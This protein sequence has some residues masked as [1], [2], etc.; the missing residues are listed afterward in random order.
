MDL[1]DGE[2]AGRSCG[3]NG[4]MVEDLWAEVRRV[5]EAASRSGALL[6]IQTSFRTLEDGG[7][8]FIVRV[9]ENLARKDAE[10]RAVLEGKARKK[11]E[12][13][14]LPYDEELFVADVSDSHVCLLN[15]YNVLEHHLLIVTRHFEH[16]DQLL[17]VEDFAALQAC[18]DRVEG[19]GFYN[20]GVIAGASQPHKHL[21]L[22]PLPLAA[23][24]DEIPIAGALSEASFEDGIGVV[25]TL[26][27]D[28]SLSCLSGDEKGR[29]LHDKYLELMD[30]VELSPTGAEPIPRA[31]YNLLVTS[32]WMLVVPRAEEHGAPGVSVNGLGFAG[33]LLVR[34]Q[35]QLDEIIRVGPMT[36]LKRSGRAPVEGSFQPSLFRS[37]PG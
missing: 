36:V 24:I 30:A 3:Y 17:T 34:N 28:H 10:R 23:G 15:K 13:P 14:F 25:P 22:V 20:G 29:D 26:P 6:P 1:M 11:D 16:Q 7:V 33:A 35:E 37:R 32:S 27:F 8:S 18:M 9:V 12:N 2:E 4:G 19:L 21:Q 31:P 5:T